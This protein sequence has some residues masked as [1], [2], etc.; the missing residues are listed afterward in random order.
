V[1][2]FVAVDWSGAI[3]AERRALWLAEVVSGRLVR[4]ESGRTREEVGDLLVDEAAR[5]PALVVGLDFAFSFP[6]WFLGSRGI[7]DARSLW[8]LLAQEGESW[9]RDPPAPFWRIRRPA[10]GDLPTSWEWRRTEL[11]AGP[12]GRTRAKS[13]F[14]LV[15]AGQVGTGSLRGMRLLDRLARSGFSVWPFDRPAFPLVVEIYPRLLT[16][17]VRKSDRAARERYLDRFPRLDSRLRA[18][19]ARDDNA[20]DAAVSAL[21]MARWRGDWSALP[22]E[23]AHE[24]EGAIWR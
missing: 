24:L 14:Q 19:A 3:R 20:F 22:R 1:P 11:E 4:L 13:V 2:R 9:L 12:V 5:D 18:L 15:G 23:P 21:A 16:G 8:A 10:G 17:A 6:A 7:G